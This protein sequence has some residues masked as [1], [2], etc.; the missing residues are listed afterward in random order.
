M[1][2]LHLVIDTNA[3]GNNRKGGFPGPEPAEPAQNFL[4]PLLP[5]VNAEVGVQQIARLH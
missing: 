4:R 2:P 1:I 3:V 5:D